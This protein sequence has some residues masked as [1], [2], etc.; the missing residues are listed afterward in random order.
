MDELFTEG[1]EV[2]HRLGYDDLNESFCR[3]DVVKRLLARLG[4]SK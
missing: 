4:V 1:V 3:R 2:A